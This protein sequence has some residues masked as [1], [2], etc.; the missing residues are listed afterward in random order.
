MMIVRKYGPPLHVQHATRDTYTIDNGE[1]RWVDR[2]GW[3]ELDDG[4]VSG[5]RD[6]G[7]IDRV[8]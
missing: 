1:V 3:R 6:R 5:V 8:F 2:R 7:R 4:Q